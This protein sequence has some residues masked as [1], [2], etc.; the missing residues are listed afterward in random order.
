MAICPIH[1]YS[2]GQCPGCD[3]DPRPLIEHFLKIEEGRPLDET[4]WAVYWH[5]L[6][7]LPKLSYLHPKGATR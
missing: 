1:S 2:L 6:C 5:Q 7:R 4:E 3:A